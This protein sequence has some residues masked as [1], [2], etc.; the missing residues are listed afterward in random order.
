M[1]SLS[2]GGTWKEGDSARPRVPIPV[3][4]LP[5][6]S[7]GCPAMRAHSKDG[8]VPRH[9]GNQPPVKSPHL[10]YRNS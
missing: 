8:L 10:A 3:P 6:A 7:P 4:I 2:Q 1:A 9:A 5:A